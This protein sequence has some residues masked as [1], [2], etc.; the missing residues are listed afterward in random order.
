M[1]RAPVRDGEIS[2]ALCKGMI[3]RNILL[4]HYPDR[5]GLDHSNTF[6]VRVDNRASVADDGQRLIADL[7]FA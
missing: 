1:T 3:Q 2:L 7:V 4:R 5:G 6:S